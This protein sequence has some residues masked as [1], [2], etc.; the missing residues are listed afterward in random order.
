MYSLFSLK[1]LVCLFLA[2]TIFS[3]MII[4]SHADQIKPETYDDLK[5][6]MFAFLD[7]PEVMTED[8]SFKGSMVVRLDTDED[9]L[10]VIRYLLDF[11]TERSVIFPVDVK[12]KDAEG[13]TKDKSNKL[14]PTESSDVYIYET[15]DNDIRTSFPISAEDGLCTRYKDYRVTIRPCGIAG[16]EQAK[17]SD[18][19]LIY[20]NAFGD[21]VD[22]CARPSFTGNK[23]DIILNERP[24]Q[25]VFSF[26]V[27]AEGL[28]IVNENGAVVIYDNDVPIAKFGEIYIKDSAKNFTYGEVIAEGSKLTLFVPE[29]FLDDPE[30]QYP[31]TVDPVLYFVTTNAYGNANIVGANLSSTQCSHGGTLL[32]APILLFNK[33]GTNTYH[34]PIIKFPNL[35]PVLTSMGSVTGATL[36]LYRESAYSGSS[37]V[38]LTARP[39]KTN[40][41]VGTNY[42][43]TVY[44]SIYNGYT[45]TNSATSN[46]SA[47]A[48]ATGSNSFNIKN[49]ANVWAG[50]NLP[51]VDAGVNITISSFNYAA[52]FHGATTATSSKMPRVSLSYNYTS[53]GQVQDGIYMIS[54]CPQIT[55]GTNSYCMTRTTNSG[56]SKPVNASE[57]GVAQR[58]YPANGKKSYMKSPTQLFRIKYTSVGYTIQSIETGEYLAF[59]NGTTLKFVSTDDNSNYTTRW[60]LVKVGSNYYIVSYFYHYLF[61]A[62]PTGSCD[63]SVKLYSE[64]DGR[65]WR[66]R[67]YMLDVEHRAQGDWTTC[68]ATSVW[69]ILNYKGVDLSDVGIRNPAH[70]DANYQSNFPVKSDYI[71]SRGRVASGLSADGNGFGCEQAGAA[72]NYYLPGRYTNWQHPYYTD[73]VTLS[74]YYNAIAFNIENDYPLV[75]LCIMVASDS[76]TYTSTGHYVIVIGAYTDS[77]NVRRVVIADPYPTSDPNFAGNQAYAYIDITVSELWTI[78]RRNSN[79]MI[80][81]NF[82][83]PIIYN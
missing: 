27:D 10:N 32:D 26:E 4:F 51:A 6:D 83:L 35:K 74:D 67:L 15:R 62:N 25:N 72:L 63:L 38:T 23:T 29:K 79:N 28:N 31:V 13:I 46:L 50:G 42:D 52:R 7:I 44:T 30:T 68:G 20:R 21:G 19:A 2:V 36:T 3:S 53:T 37:A 9:P 65:R 33:T 5:T 47:G 39:S 12:Y 82:V 18:N 43:G 60:S 58:N 73:S 57:L 76:F 48:S 41:Q 64:S 77:N 71:Y 8:E 17:L 56:I 49:M 54:A 78:T 45:T 1:K 16:G 70:V 24:S 69:M 11:E 22:F 66:L 40:W 34:N 14:Y 61:A 75:F 80:C 55:G 59:V 81:N